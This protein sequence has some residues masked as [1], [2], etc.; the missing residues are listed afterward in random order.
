MKA[1][2]SLSLLPRLS[3]SST[4]S[5]FL[6]CLRWDTSYC[7]NTSTAHLLASSAYSEQP[8]SHYFTV[9]SFKPSNMSATCLPEGRVGT[10]CIQSKQWNFYVCVIFHLF[11]PPSSSSS[12]ALSVSY[13]APS[14][15]FILVLNAFTM[16][17]LC[18]L[19]RCIMPFGYDSFMTS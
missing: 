19:N 4:R 15:P 16:A 12:S 6:T 10:A 3:P 11:P 14:L 13:S 9:F 18:F 2:V 7:I 17:R 5:L 1:S 8:N